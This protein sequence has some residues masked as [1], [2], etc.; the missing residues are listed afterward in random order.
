M[1]RPTLLALLTAGTLYGCTDAP[2]PTDPLRPM[3]VGG[4][5]F[6]AFPGTNGKIVF[7][8]QRDG[9][10][11]FVMNADGSGV[12]RINSRPSINPAW[13]PDG[14]RIAFS[15]YVAADDNYEIFV[16]N[17]DG[18]GET[19][20]TT[21]AG[22]DFG[23]SWSPNGARIAF[24]SDRSGNNEIYVMDANGAN[25][26]NLTNLASNDFAPSWSPDGSKILFSTDRDGLGEIYVMNTDGSSPT[27]LTNNTIHDYDPSWSPD[28]TRIVFGRFVGATE[29][30]AVM[31]ADGSGQTVITADVGAAVPSWSPDGAKIIFTSDRDGNNEIYVMNPDG[32]NATRLTNDP[33]SDN[34]ADWQSIPA[35]APKADVS[36][37]MA[38]AAQKVAKTVMYTIAVRNAGP[39]AAAGVTL[40]DALPAAARFVSINATQGS[41]STPTPGSSGSVTCAL[42]S[43]A[44]SGKATI[45]IT[46][47]IIPP[48]SQ[49]NNTASVSSSTIDPNSANNTVTVQTP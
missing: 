7:T 23:P 46:V 15:G 27:N 8:S 4:P 28:G 40:T 44:M 13:S 16:M 1:R 26:A 32:T 37:E 17:S 30:I 11:I 35:N 25:V 42:G 49:P 29:Q 5:R 36:I 33:G 2:R 3:N 38:A 24:Y 43:L 41:C 19:R 39:N 12:Q 6:G 48:N 45:Q 14:T 18:T 9:G 22:G 20:L 47:K 10:G 21:N 34:Q 31:N